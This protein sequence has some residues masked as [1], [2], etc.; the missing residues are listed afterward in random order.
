MRIVVI[1]AAAMLV[2][3]GASAG[4]SP[5]RVAMA[6]SGGWTATLSYR[7]AGG[8]AFPEVRSLR[9]AVSHDGVQM[10]L[11]AL[12][13]PRDCREYPCTRIASPGFD[14][15]ELAD[16][17]LDAPVALVWLWTGGA[18]CCSVVKLVPLSG[19]TGIDRNFGDPGASVATLD[20]ERVLVS[21]DDRFAYLF[22]S[23]AA[24][25]LPVQVWRFDGTKL[26]DV[27]ADHP[28]V[29]RADARAMWATYVQQRRSAQGETRGVF[30]AWAADMCV[31]GQRARRD[32]LLVDGLAHG[33]F[34]R[35][36]A[37]DLL[38]PHGPAYGKALRHQ[39]AAFGYCR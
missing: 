3:A 4:T 20:G 32:R 13:L 12:P 15:L 29:V 26:V 7:L 10:G 17:G 33:F 37:S 21:A 27:T 23:Y 14:F 38:G 1:A 25:G 36:A 16:L 28:K 9:L 22:T 11:R 5:T 30:A 35:Q 8:R 2:A 19:G 6:S 18:H 39:L 24:S 31:L 34:S